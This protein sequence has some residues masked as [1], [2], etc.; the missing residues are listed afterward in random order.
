MLAICPALIAAL[1]LS[2]CAGNARPRPQEAD[3]PAATA[4]AATAT[5][6]TAGRRAT[7][8]NGEQVYCKRE[9]LT[10]SRTQSIETCLTAAQLEQQRN[11]VDA[12]MRRAQETRAGGGD[13]SG[14]RFNNVMT[15]GGRAGGQ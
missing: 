3:A 1:V 8:R 4:A 15:S 11:N 6:A 5:P 10:G 13:G 2:A 9:L 12:M 7:T 14:G